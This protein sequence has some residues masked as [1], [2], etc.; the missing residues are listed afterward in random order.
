FLKTAVSALS[1]AE[2]NIIS[3]ITA[4]TAVNLLLMK[5]D[6]ER[7]ARLIEELHIA[8]VDQI[9]PV[10]DVA[11]IGVVGE[12]LDETRGLAAR[13]FKAVAGAGANVEMIAS[14]A[15]RVTQYFIIKERDRDETVRSIHREF[16]GTPA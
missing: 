12:G 2:I 6:V 11:L 1:D 3:V 15:S 10:T 5:A 8:Y 4:Q 14:G 13:V 7:S 9:E 16:F